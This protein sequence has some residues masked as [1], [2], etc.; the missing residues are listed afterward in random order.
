[1]YLAQVDIRIIYRI[2]EN[3]IE[4]VDIFAT[5]NLADEEVFQTLEAIKRLK[6]K[7]S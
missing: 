1:M 3:Q 2:E 6:L 7:A 4:I 5:V